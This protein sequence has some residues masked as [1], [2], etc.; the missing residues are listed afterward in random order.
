MITLIKRWHDSAREKRLNQLF[1]KADDNGDGMITSQQ[2][3]ELFKTNGI[4]ST[5]LNEDSQAIAD[6]DGLI[7]RIT[8]L[9]YAVETDLC[10]IETQDRVFSQ[11]LWPQSRDIEKRRK[12][13]GNVKKELRRTDSSKMDRVE[14]AF[15]HFDQNKDGYLDRQEFNIMMANV[16]KEQAERIFRTCNTSGEDRIS[17]PEFRAMLNKLPDADNGLKSDA[18][19]IQSSKSISSDGRDTGSTCCQCFN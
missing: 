8:F 17:L 16:P 15:R 5:T 1:E 11:P 2:I 12:S 6:K 18:A 3:I 4:V 13:D 14:Y 7:S 10:K 9:K 19:S